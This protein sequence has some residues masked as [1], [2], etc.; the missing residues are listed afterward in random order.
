[1]WL[2]HGSILGIVDMLLLMVEESSSYTVVVTIGDELLCLFET[3][4]IWLTSL[5]L[6]VGDGFLSEEL[7]LF[8]RM[9]LLNRLG[10]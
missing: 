6:A 9:K 1:M 7:E 3:W 2:A 10:S 8:T 4:G 5:T